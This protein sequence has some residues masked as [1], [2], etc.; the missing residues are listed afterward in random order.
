MAAVRNS[1]KHK[2]ALYV[3]SCVTLQGVNQTQQIRLL[4]PQDPLN[5]TSSIVHQAGHIAVSDSPAALLNFR[6]E[7]ERWTS[8]SL[9]SRVPINWYHIYG[10]ICVSSV[11]VNRSTTTYTHCCVPSIFNHLIVLLLKTFEA[12]NTNK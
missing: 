5:I 4:Y 12:Q 10:G 3:K 9:V 6:R 2:C 11:C 8:G 7:E 1:S